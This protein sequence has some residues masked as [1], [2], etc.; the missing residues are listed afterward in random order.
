LR[1]A[2]FEELSAALQHEREAFAEVL[3]SQ[4]A[5]EGIRAFAEKREPVYRDA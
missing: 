1:R 5:Q 2:R 4:D 3:Q